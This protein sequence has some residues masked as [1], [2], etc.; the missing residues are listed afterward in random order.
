M[1]EED[2]QEVSGLA[3]HIYNLM[4]ERDEPLIALF[5]LRDDALESWTKVG[6]EMALSMAQNYLQQKRI[7]KANGKE[8]SPPPT[9]YDDYYKFL[10]LQQQ[11]QQRNI[12]HQTMEQDSDQNDSNDSKKMKLEPSPSFTL[13]EKYKTLTLQQQQHFFEKLQSAFDFLNSPE[14]INNKNQSDDDFETDEEKNN[15]K[16]K[17]RDCNHVSKSSDCFLAHKKRHTIEGSQ[18]KK[19]GMWCGKLGSLR[20]HQFEFHGV[21]KNYKC[22]K[23]SAILKSISGLENHQFQKHKI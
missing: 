14:N 7:D 17:W 1:E 4:C 11:Q 21:P 16:C 13:Q 8:H 2:S 18:C 6:Q 3:D 9:T 20:I 23:C 10:P 19:C 22:D 15:F 12:H 5:K